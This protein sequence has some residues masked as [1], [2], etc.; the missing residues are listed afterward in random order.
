[1]SELQAHSPLGASGAY[2]WMVCPG[3]VGNSEGVIDP[4]S[5]FAA[6]GT[7]A[8]TLASDCL[9]SAKDAWP[10]IGSWYDGQDIIPAGT[11]CDGALEVD[12]DMADAVQVYLD[13][14]RYEYPD[15][16][17]GNTWVERKF[18]C[19][20]IH[21]LFYGTADFIHYDKANS[22]LHVWDYKHGAGIVVDVWGNPQLMYYACGALED[23]GLW[24]DVNDI[25][26]HVAQPRGWHSDGPIREWSL[27]TEQLLSWMGDVLVPAMNRA[28][29][30]TDT[31]SGD[32]C[33]FCPARWRACPQLVADEKELTELMAKMKKKGGAKK[34]SNKDIARLL[35]LGEVMKISIKAA[36]ENGFA[37]AEGGA[38]IP[39]WKLVKARSNREFK[40]TAEKAAIKKFGKAKA[41]TTPELKSPAKIDKLPGGKKFTTEYAFKPE[42]GMQLVQASDARNEAGP[43]TRSMF[44]PQHNN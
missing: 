2:R 42:K 36:R 20:D 40:E 17:Q 12:K 16:N 41:F 23:L 33:R 29:T 10:F 9:E 34:L 31:A 32:H 25:V 27:T 22:K 38:E 26:L 5:E 6:V 30:S 43:S 28:Q 18:H 24:D 44:K 13:A 14:V 37:R 1:M 35:D 7:A 15:Q 19:P 21:E 8:H 3:S 4:E 39:G 11:P